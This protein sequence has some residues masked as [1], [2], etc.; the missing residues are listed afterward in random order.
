MYEF[1]LNLEIV[2][3]EQKTKKWLAGHARGIELCGFQKPL[4]R[5]RPI[6]VRVFGNAIRKQGDTS[7]EADVMDLP[8]CD[9][10]LDYV[11]ASH[12][13]EYCANP[14][15]ALVEWARVARNGGI[16]Y[17][18]VFDRRHTWERYRKAVAVEHL[19]DDYFS[20]V[21]QADG[22]H[23]DEYVDTV[24]WE[25]FSPGDP[26]EVAR[27]RYRVELKERIES[28]EEVNIRHHAY[29]PASLLSAVEI[30]NTVSPK[31]SSL[32][33]VDFETRFPEKS[34]D[35]FLAVLKVEKSELLPVERIGL[36]D[37]IRAF[38]SPEGVLAP[39]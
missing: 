19:T 18:V 4:P 3:N 20:G 7:I 5:I 6:Q 21:R 14:V 35:G 23:I 27:E 12:V 13:L 9:G 28:G 11:A 33:L 1:C 32:E 36:L 25:E 17:L 16:L 39:T 37:R 30:A 24:V 10:E 2:T 29:D 15:G 34:R 26:S 8:F 38:L 31:G 22:S